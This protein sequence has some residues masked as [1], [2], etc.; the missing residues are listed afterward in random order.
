MLYVQD[1]VRVTCSN[2]GNASGR[3][4][5]S[6]NQS[7]DHSYF[8]SRPGFVRLE[9][10]YQGMVGVLGDEDKTRLTWLVNMDFGGLVPSSFTTVFLVTIMAFPLKAVGYTKEYLKKKEGEVVDIVKS[11]LTHES[12]QGEEEEGAGKEVALKSKRESAAEL[13]LKA[14]L[15][16]MKTEM[17]RK[18]KELRRKDEELRRKDEELM[19]KDEAL[20]INDEEHRNA[21]ADKDKE[22]MELRRRLPRVL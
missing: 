8:A 18:D 19:G 13:A 1:Y 17:A 10:K 9:M 3:W 22:I 4:F 6:Y 16:E 20:R 11:K 21:L 15:A 7:F 5:Y 2:D 12:S 14:E